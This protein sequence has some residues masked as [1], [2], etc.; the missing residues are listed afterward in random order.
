[1]NV[2]L[3]PQDI[4]TD[5]PFHLLHLKVEGERS[6][7]MALLQ[8]CQAELTRE[9]RHL[10]N[11]GSERLIKEHRVSTTLLPNQHGVLISAGKRLQCPAEVFMPLK[12]QTSKF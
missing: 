6:K 4:Q 11:M 9:N 12:L 8:E 3:L 2:I 5:A 10:A 7:L 1:M